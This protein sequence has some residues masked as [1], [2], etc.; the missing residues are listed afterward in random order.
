M[1]RAITLTTVLYFAVPV[2]ARD[3]SVDMVPFNFDRY[4]GNG[5][6][7]N[8]NDLPGLIYVPSDVEPGERLPIVLNL[9]GFG[10]RG[11]NSQVQVS[12]GVFQPDNRSQANGN[13]DN[14][15]TAA[16]NNR[17]ILYTPQAWSGWGGGGDALDSA[18][19]QVA[20]ATRQYAV[21][22]DRIYLAGLSNGGGGVFSTLNRYAHV[23]PAAV[24][25][26][27]QD[28]GIP[29]NTDA[30]KD[31]PLWMFHGQ[32]DTTVL[33]SASRNR[34]NALRAAK[35]LSAQSFPVA[36]NF[37]DDGVI[38]YTEY[39][40]VGHNS[41]S[42]AYDTSAL[43]SWML[44][45]SK[46]IPTLQAGQTALFDL[47]ASQV[48]GTPGGTTYNTTAYG[49]SSVIGPAKSFA[50]TTTGIGTQVAL[51]VTDR[52]N[53]ETFNLNA[54]LNDSW[55]VTTSDA[56]QIRIFGLTPGDSYDLEFFSSSTSNNGSTRF[57]V[58]GL[59]QDLNHFNNTATTLL[60]NDVLAD[61][62]GALLFDV[63]AT[64]GS[65]GTGYLTWFGITAVP[66]PTVVGL[67]AP[68]AIGLASRRRRN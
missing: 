29:L 32:S 22:P 51:E 62:T 68:L 27:A 8:N 24:A 37:Y 12:P 6:E 10:E 25:I 53:G 52:F 16:K 2:M 3:N 54:P 43:Y 56:G 35:G 13:I 40:N 60:F 30:V 44:A 28:L 66:E 48:S 34:I 15:M 36:G 42:R 63:L 23:F 9:H 46:P 17:F 39:P 38:R 4:N 61:S 26:C 33:P 5:L 1:L 55:T 47:G 21:D 19:N 59:T 65:S 31:V 67:L 7:P 57:V 20:K 45:K 50:K 58:D 18:M 14:L 49:L 11:S 41:W 64:P